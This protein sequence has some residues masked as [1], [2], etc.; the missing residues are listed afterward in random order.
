[1]FKRSKQ[2]FV[3]TSSVI[4]NIQNDKFPPSNFEILNFLAPK[5]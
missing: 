2:L 3:S 4:P 1:M 5:S